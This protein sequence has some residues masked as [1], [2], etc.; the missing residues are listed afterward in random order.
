M[1]ASCYLNKLPERLTAEN[2]ILVV[3]PMLAT[4]E[5]FCPLNVTWVEKLLACTPVGFWHAPRWFYHSCPVLHSRPPLP[6]C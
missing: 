4:G 6:P 2:R 3:D 5:G 1:Q